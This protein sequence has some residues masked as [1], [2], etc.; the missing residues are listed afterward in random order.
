MEWP[1]DSAWGALNEEWSTVSDCGELF[2]PTGQLLVCDPCYLW[3]SE[4]SLGCRVKLA[5]GRYPVKI[6]W[7]G[8]YSTYVSLI[9]ST[10]PEVTRKHISCGSSQRIEYLPDGVVAEGE[11]DE[12]SGFSVETATACL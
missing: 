5:P 4:P 7:S 1:N 12:F 3:S 9:L 2:L 11:E 8:R 6:T 10:S